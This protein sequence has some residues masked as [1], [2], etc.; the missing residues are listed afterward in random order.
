MSKFINLPEFITGMGAAL[1]VF[2]ILAMLALIIVGPFI[3]IWAINT[4]FGFTIGY[5]FKTWFA[6]LV[7]HNVVSGGR[8]A[9]VVKNND[10]D[11]K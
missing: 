1:I 8:W 11:E 7:V 5:T 3:T 4:L 2:V 9:S 6:M 10:K